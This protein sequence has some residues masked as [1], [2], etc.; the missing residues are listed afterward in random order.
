[1][2][3]YTTERL[4]PRKERTPEGFLVCYDVPI[5]RTGYQKY[6]PQEL[7]ANGVPAGAY[8]TGDGGLVDVYRP[9]EEVFRDAT[10]ASAGGKPVVIYHP[11]EDVDPSNWAGLS[12]GHMLNIRRGSGADSGLVLADLMITHPDGI[13]L[14][15]GPHKNS[16][17]SCGYSCDYVPAHGRVEQ[18]N[19]VINHLA[20]VPQ[21]RCGP[22]CATRDAATTGEKPAMPVKKPGL[23]GALAK[24]WKAIATN[25][26]SQVRD[27]AAELETSMAEPGSV[28]DHSIVINNSHRPEASDD[29]PDDDLQARVAQMEQEHAEMLQDLEEIK[30]ALDLSDGQIADMR[31]RRGGDP[32]RKNGRNR[33]RS[34]TPGRP[35]AA[36][37]PH[38]TPP[39]VGPSPDDPSAEE[40]EQIEQEAPAGKGQDTRTARDSVLLAGAWRDVVAKAEILAPGIT[41]PEFDPSA[42]PA[43]TVDALCRIRADALERALADRKNAALL[44]EAN[45][46]RR[47]VLKDMSC[48]AKRVLFHGA[49]T[50]K[51]SANNGGIGPIGL[52]H[53]L[54]NESAEP[55]DFNR[56]MDLRYGRAR[57]E[58]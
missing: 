33:D 24:V 5:A 14:L 41:V 2:K 19:I 31:A 20:L 10:L 45:G 53:G 32:T 16:E 11:D 39:Y 35:P 49:A 42:R 26:I 40:A 30:E 17:V 43:R 28:S 57:T 4:S 37:Q 48:D 27:A 25:D 1:M 23:A 51:A 13:A 29:D 54:G 22:L 56:A 47:V 36:W 34:K 15:A 6:L 55:F 18:R 3:L 52:Y 58:A 21:G 46:G 12:V 8:R 9:P 38:A 7:A 50:L 44:A